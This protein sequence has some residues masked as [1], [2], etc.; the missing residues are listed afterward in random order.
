[1]IEILIQFIVITFFAL[2]FAALIAGLVWFFLNA[3]ENVKHL[4]SESE[5]L[6]KIIEE[7][8]NEH[9]QVL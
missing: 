1:M 7:Q 9:A 8:E 4:K 5:R 2:L 3:L 6:K